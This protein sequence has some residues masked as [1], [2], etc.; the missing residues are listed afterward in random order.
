[1]VLTPRRWRQVLRRQVA[2]QPG[3]ACRYSRGDGGKRARSPGRARY[4]PLKPLRGESR[5][6]PSEPVVTTLVCFIYFAR[7]AAGA[8]GTRLSLR[9]LS[10][11]GTNFRHDP[12]ALRRGIER[13]SVPGC[14][15]LS[16]E[17][18]RFPVYMTT[19]VIFEG[20]ED[21]RDSAA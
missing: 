12:G 21:A 19:V 14:L 20:A 6:I 18:A 15:A 3:Q 4:K 7:E 11:G 16:L 13:A 17:K 2:A 8:T 5:L 1:M 10:L 9:P